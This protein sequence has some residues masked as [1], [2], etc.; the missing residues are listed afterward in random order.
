[1]VSEEARTYGF[2]SAQ[3]FSPESTFGLQQRSINDTLVK[4]RENYPGT[5]LCD[6]GYPGYGRLFMRDVAKSA[7]ML[8]DASMMKDLLIVASALQAR[9]SNPDNG[10]E[11]G[12]I[13]HEKD[14]KM[15]TAGK[16]P[17]RPGD[18]GYNACDSTA[19]YLITHEEYIE[20]TGDRSLAVN[21]R[22]SIEDGSDYILN[23]LDSSGI[24]VEDPRACGANQF[25]LRVTYWKDSIIPQRETGEPSYPVVY[26]FAHMQNLSGLRSAARLLNSQELRRK[27]DKMAQA[28]PDL[29]DESTD[30]FLLASDSLG[31]IKG[32]STD[33]LHALVYL[34]PGD[35]PAEI[36]ERIINTSSKLET[37]AGYVVLDPKVGEKMNDKYHADPVWTHEQ[38]EIHKGARKHKR[39]AESQGYRGLEE[40]LAH[41]MEVASGVKSYFDQN[42]TSHPELLFV[43]GSV[44]P[45]GCDPQLW[46]VAAHQY[47]LNN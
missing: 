13:F 41:V 28:I 22:G 4:L 9:G 23:H 24:F 16:I 29:F 18:A 25:N 10:A 36:L 35:L 17:D 21:L 2:E 15:G 1:M 34:E 47:F 42:P 11:Y 27:A 44:E 19:E 3:A 31:D 20:R 43:N 26:P 30:S 12:K 6:A 5:R 32:Y 14:I 39:W 33:N 45:G 46:A 38:A 7:R 40:G 8:G 37:R